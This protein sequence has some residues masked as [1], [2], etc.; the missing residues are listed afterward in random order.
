MIITIIEWLC[1]IFGLISEDNYPFFYPE[2]HESEDKI[3]D[4]ILYPWR[5]NDRNR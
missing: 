4:E 5:F 2:L 3:W 1:E